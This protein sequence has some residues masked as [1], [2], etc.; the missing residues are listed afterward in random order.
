MHWFSLTCGVLM[1]ADVKHSLFLTL[2][3]GHGDMQGHPP[4]EHAWL[5]EKGHFAKRKK[6]SYTNSMP[7]DNIK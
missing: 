3:Q 6:H 4:I 7:R 2:I 5:I 1:C